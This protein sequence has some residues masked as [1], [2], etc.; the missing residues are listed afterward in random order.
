MGVL[1]YKPSDLLIE[2]YVETDD[3]KTIIEGIPYYDTLCDNI[4]ESL[5]G[6]IHNQLFRVVVFTVHNDANRRMQ[7]ELV[8]KV[9]I[10]DGWECETDNHGDN[11]NLI[12]WNPYRNT[13]MCRNKKAIDNV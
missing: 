4:N 8:F 2:D 1:F 13:N 7:L 12:V 5:R 6:M 9:L 10:S 11:I 3:E